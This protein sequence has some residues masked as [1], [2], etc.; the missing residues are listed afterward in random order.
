MLGLCWVSWWRLI[1]K[2]GKLEADTSLKEGLTD[3]GGAPSSAQITKTQAISDI[4]NARQKYGNLGAS[5]DFVKRC[6]AAI[7]II[8]EIG[9]DTAGIE[10]VTRQELLNSALT[11]YD[12]KHCPVCDTPLTPEVFERHVRTKLARYDF[13][14]KRRASLDK[15]LQEIRTAIMA[16]GLALRGVADFAAQIK[17]KPDMADFI[18]FKGTLLAQYTQIDVVLP[19]G[20]TKSVLEALIANP[21]LSPALAKIEAIVAALPER[22]QQDEARDFLT[23]AQERLEKF[24]QAKK[25]TVAADKRSQ[26]ASVIYA[27][28]GDVTTVELEKI[29]KNVETKFAEYYRIINKEDEGHPSAQLIPSAGKLDLGVDFYNRGFFPPHAYHSEGHQDG[30]G[31]CLY[32]AL[33]DHILGKG[34]TFA[35]LDDV[36]MS[37]DAG[38]R[39]EVCRLLMEKFPHTQFVFTTHDDIWLKHMASAGLIIGRNFA[40]FR[41]WS[42][43][44]G[45]TDWESLDIWA[46]LGNCLSKNDVRSAAALLRHYLEYFAKEAC[47]GLRAK[48][49]F[50]GDAQFSL[51][52]VLPSAIQ[53]LGELLKNARLAAQS[54]DQQGTVDAITALEA[55]FSASKQAI[56]Y[57]QWQINFAVHFN[58][59]DNLQR[60]DFDPVVAAF[61]EFTEN[62][63]CGTCRSALHAIP[64]FGSVESVKCGC[65]IVNLNLNKKPGQKK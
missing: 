11:L 14:T 52:D 20:D 41:N 64:S 45:P 50:K 62:F 22:S 30:M 65:G 9:T 16:A 61:K 56:Q 23:I 60:T 6:N 34:F 25:N 15:E 29:Y 59:W 37:V 7:A 33:M 63:A 54:W 3:A 44:M 40:R 17:P 8:D 18:A 28:Y 13:I 57:D 19:L 48:V 5:K 39:R 35:V 42:V 2:A 58:D 53:R 47:G 31:L 51:S 55:R 10:G 1:H 21:D 32:L 12:G 43:D 49:E 46:E 38:H 24:R 27:T 4:A 36:V 26:R